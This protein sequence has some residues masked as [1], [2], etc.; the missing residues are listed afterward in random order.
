MNR[1]PE[2]LYFALMPKAEQESA[3]RRLAASGMSEHT[4]A[5]A[6]GLSVEQVRRVLAS[7]DG[8]PLP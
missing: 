4:I 7:Q 5:A 6:S 8:A 3:L 1:A 2:R